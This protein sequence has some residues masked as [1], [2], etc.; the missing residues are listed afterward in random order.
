M[1]RKIS[2]KASALNTT[3]DRQSQVEAMLSS[4]E[5]WLN[6][7]QI[8]SYLEVSE[9]TLARWRE[10]Q[11]IPYSKMGGTIFYPKRLLNKLFLNKIKPG[12]L[13]KI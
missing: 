2:G 9:R 7:A 11:Q 13:K 10:N 5:V 8:M 12:I 1:K 3:P 6:T 4:N